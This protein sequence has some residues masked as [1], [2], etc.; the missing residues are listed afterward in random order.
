MSASANSVVSLRECNQGLTDS[1]VGQAPQKWPYRLPA[2]QP[3]PLP[4]AR[5]RRRTCDRRMDVHL[6]VHVK[7]RPRADKPRPR[8]R[9]AVVL[10]AKSKRS[11]PPFSR[12]D[13]RNDTGQHRPLEKED[14]ETRGACVPSLE[15]CLAGAELFRLCAETGPR[16]RACPCV[17]S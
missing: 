2:T 15:T 8:A 13:R 4:A 17:C 12:L 6:D 16:P 3:A 9:Q 7:F 10:R 1:G 5:R 11:R 14:L